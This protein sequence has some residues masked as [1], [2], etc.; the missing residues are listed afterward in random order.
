[1]SAEIGSGRLGA[2][3]A[4][5]IDSP[6]QPLILLPVLYHL[7]SLMLSSYSE[8]TRDALLILCLIYS[9]GLGIKRISCAFYGE[10]SHDE[11]AFRIVITEQPSLV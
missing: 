4:L 7:A 5:H 6:P 3:S 2:R 11:I 1:M 10:Q 8:N 9:S